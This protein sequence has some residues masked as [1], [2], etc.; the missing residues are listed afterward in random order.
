M[1]ISPHQQRTTKYPWPGMAS[2]VAI[3]VAVVLVLLIA[4]VLIADPFRNTNEEPG[5]A[6][7]LITAAD[8]L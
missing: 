8:R 2:A 5:P 4:Y 1:N 7:T 3:V 6:T